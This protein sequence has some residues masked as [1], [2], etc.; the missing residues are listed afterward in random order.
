M[1]LDTSYIFDIMDGDEA[2]HRTGQELTDSG[3][4]QWLPSPVVAEVYYGV[5][6]AKSEQERR[7]VENA[8][9]GYPRVDVDEEIARRAS[10]LLADADRNAGGVGASGVETNDAYI[11]GIADTLGEPVLTGNPDDFETLGVAVETY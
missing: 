4:I 2:A 10:T 5:T 1:I 11:A 6:Y 9:L 3:A 8:L 7:Q